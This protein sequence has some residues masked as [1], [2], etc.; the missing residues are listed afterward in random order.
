M[1]RTLVP[2]LV[3]SLRDYPRGQLAGDLTA[4]VIVGNEWRSV[5]A[6]LPAPRSD[7]IVL[8]ITFLLTVVVDLTVATEVGV[9]MAAFLFMKRMAE[10]TNVSVI[11]REF[12][13]NVDETDADSVR[14]RQVPRGGVVYEINGPFFFGAA[15]TFKD[16]LARTMG[17]P[18][19]LILRLR[20]VPAIDATGMHTLMDVVRR[21]R[22]DGT[23]GLLVAS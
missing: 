2:Q 17:K 14:T 8:A 22:K 13:G 12:R 10:V 20:N 6:L 7:V 16:T 15:E 11:S 5:R 4:G 21:T 18:R 3:T 19:V 1:S 23:L 9:V